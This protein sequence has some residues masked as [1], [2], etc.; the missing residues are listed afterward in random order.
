MLTLKLTQEQ[1][2]L[3][4]FITPKKEKNTS[5]FSFGTEKRSKEQKKFL[6][7]EGRETRVQA[8]PVDHDHIS[9]FIRGILSEK[10]NLLLDQ[11]EKKTYGK[12]SK[13][14]ELSDYQNNPPAFKCIGRVKY[15]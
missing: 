12:L 13:P 8:P 4:E 2:E 5:T 11:W 3:I 1:H 14:Q 7:I 9:G 6:D 10:V 15:K